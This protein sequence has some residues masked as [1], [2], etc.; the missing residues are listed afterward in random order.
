[1]IRTVPDIAARLGI[2]SKAVY[3]LGQSHGLERHR[4]KGRIAYDYAEIKAKHENPRPRGRK[5]KAVSK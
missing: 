1:M 5:R 2:S 4:L 3:W